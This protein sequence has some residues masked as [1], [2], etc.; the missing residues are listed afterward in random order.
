MRDRNAFGYAGGARG[1]DQVGEV[2]G[3]RRRQRG[4]GPVF[5]L[6]IVDGD[7]RDVV[8]LEPV[9]EPGTGE[10]GDRGGVGEHEAD[11]L[12]RQRRIDR[13]VGRPGLQHGK[14]GDDRLG[15]A[16]KQQRHSLSRARA[17]GGEQ[18]REPV[19]RL[20]ELAVG[21]RVA[22]AYHRGGVRGAGRLGGEQRR[23]RLGLGGRSGQRR[24]VAEG[25]QSGVFG[26]VEQVH[27][28]Q[29]LRG[30]GGHREQHA[31]QPA[32]ERRDAVGVEDVGAEFHGAADSG[33][34]TRVAPA[35][36]HRERQ[37]HSGGVGV[38]RDG[39]DVDIAEGQS[40]GGPALLPGEVLPGQ[41]HLHQRVMAQAAGGIEPLDQHLEG[42][43][44]VLVG[45][46]AAVAH[47][48]QQLGEGGIAA[49]IF[50]ID[51]Q[52]ECVDEEP[53]QLV[54]RGVAA[55]GD[56]ETHRHIGTR[57]DLRQQHHQGGLDH[58]E[59]GGVVS[60]RHVGDPL[61]QLGRPVDLHRG[62]AL[63]GHQ[64]VGPVG[65]QRQ[66]LRHSGQGLFP[67]RQLGGDAAV[68]V[69]EIAE[70]RTLPQRVVD[71]LHRQRRP[72]GAAPVAPGGIRH[73]QVTH[74]RGEGHA[75]GG[76]VVHDG[77]QHV[78]VVADAEKL[79]PQG[80]LGRQ[81]EGVAGGGADRLVQLVRRPGAGVD[82][83]PP[84]VCLVGGDHHL[85]R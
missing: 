8:A 80:D 5:E 56:R 68:A 43:V 2:V 70:L 48:G 45:G 21:H 78:P 16:R 84:E 79:C 31:L 6:G 81:V 9:G 44:L 18:V 72:V 63:V 53:D 33:G 36:A 50:Q 37:I 28:R 73:A 47:L 64:R 35:F 40:R 30:V 71:V 22:V 83:L 76:D 14:D 62:A 85:L 29:R 51:P 60:A 38:D 24:A 34:F 59:A 13:Q 3:P 74:Q 11:P 26:V 17:P 57:A 25:V 15:R 12:G 49:Q 10:R 4:R 54:E 46:Q 67:V 58:H 39:R 75:V 65:G 69:V 32:D 41:H 52:Y 77:D 61:L 7:D 42:H 23:D 27:R 20:V 19:R 66:P 82:D 1:V 55:A